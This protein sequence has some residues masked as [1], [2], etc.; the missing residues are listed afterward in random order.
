MKL[1][2]NLHKGELDD[3]KQLTKDVSAIGHLGNGDYEIRISDT[4]NLEYIMSLIKQALL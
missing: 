1:W 4:K 2:I 3:P